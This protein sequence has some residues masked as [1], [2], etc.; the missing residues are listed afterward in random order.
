MSSSI[1]KSCCLADIIPQF[2]FLIPFGYFP[3]EDSDMMIMMI[4]ERGRG[5]SSSLRGIIMAFLHILAG[6]DSAEMDCK[7]EDSFDFI[8]LVIVTYSFDLSSFRHEN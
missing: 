5:Q 6:L 7:D 2:L 3:N 4:G 1:H 8:V